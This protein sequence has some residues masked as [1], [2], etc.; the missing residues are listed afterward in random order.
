MERYTA[1]NTSATGHNIIEAKMKNS[2]GAEIFASSSFWPTSHGRRSRF[3]PLF[4]KVCAAGFADP[5]PPSQVRSVLDQWVRRGAFQQPIKPHVAIQSAA[6]VKT[7]RSFSMNS[8]DSLSHDQSKH[9]FKS[10][11]KNTRFTL[12]DRD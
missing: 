10:A 4:K 11:R 3:R 5:T 6:F 9:Q 8:T 7:R 12:N 2:N 1:N